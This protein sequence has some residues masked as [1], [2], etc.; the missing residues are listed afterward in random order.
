MLKKVCGYGKW[1]IAGV[2]LH[3]CMVSWYGVDVLFPRNSSLW[4]CVLVHCFAWRVYNIVPADC[5]AFFLAV[6]S[7]I[8]IDVYYTVTY[9]AFA[10]H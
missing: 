7:V 10:V 4:G 2:Y 8:H 6:V 5:K 9:I 1:G 3:V